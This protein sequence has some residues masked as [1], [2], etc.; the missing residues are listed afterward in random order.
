MQL[1]RDRFTQTARSFTCLSLFLISSCSDTT[2]EGTA[3]SPGA[4]DAASSTGTANDET[5]LLQIPPAWLRT[6][7]QSTETFRLVEYLPAG[8][9]D[10]DWRDKISVESS[11]LSP[12]PDPIAA[13]IALGEELKRT[14][15][16]SDHQPISSEFEN[17]YE[18]SVRLFN[19]FKDKTTERGRVTLVKAIKG[20]DH[21]YVIS[22]SRRTEPLDTSSSPMQ[23]KEMAEWT[24]YMRSI[25]LC[26]T[27]DNEAHPC[28]AASLKMQPAENP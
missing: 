19:C 26:D 10:D 2:S 21:F 6:T 13:L 28:P 15:T 7:E 24:L 4:A 11:S 22:R 16:R 12:L 20:T 25:K 8:Q 3:N 27:R 17:G 18:S 5:L 1:L 14:C 23:G 9:D